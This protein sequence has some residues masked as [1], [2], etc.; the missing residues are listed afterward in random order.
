MLKTP[1]RKR[2]VTHPAPDVLVPFAL[3]ANDSL[4]AEHVATCATCRTEVEALREASGS[5]R[6]SA[7]FDQRIETPACPDELVIADFV[8]GRLVSDVRARV[9][10]HLLTC[11]RCRALVRATAGIAATWPA[12][13]EARKRGW[14][15][16]AV[17]L[18]AA[19][20]AL[21]ILVWPRPDDGTA[22]NLR[23]P[24]LTRTVAPTPIHPRTSVARLERLVWSSVPH[25]ERY[26]A[27]LYDDQG[28]VLWQVETTD[29]AV[30]IPA[31]QPL[32]PGSYFWRVEAETEWRR[33]AASD[34]I[35]F[36]IAAGR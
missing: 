35:A 4:T 33:W 14:H 26:R 30:A 8:E 23:E 11:A 18:A 13:T 19:A 16:W 28:T 10:D 21:I 20:A 34:L 5:L 24:A 7:L 1:L 17:P 12:P 2:H 31:G 36:R 22:P 3:G 32:P 29:T 9:V 25:A 15:R 27:R 6:A